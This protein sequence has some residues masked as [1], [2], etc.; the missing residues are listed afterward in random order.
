LSLNIIIILQRGMY[1]RTKV[2][3]LVKKLC[4]YTVQKHILWS[5][6]FIMFGAKKNTSCFV[7]IK[8]NFVF[9]CIFTTNIQKTWES[10]NTG[11]EHAYIISK[12]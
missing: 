4:T 12:H 7:T 2:F 5:R 6:L 11:D 1:Q 8:G 3:R 10:T 9:S